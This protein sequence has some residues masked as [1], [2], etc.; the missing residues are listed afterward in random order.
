M[1]SN[2]VPLPDIVIPSGTAV[3]GMVSGV[4]QYEDSFGIMLYSPATLPESV[5]IECTPDIVATA[6]STWYPYETFDVSGNSINLF[7]P[8]AGKCQVYQEP[9]FAGSF[10]LHSTTNVAADRTFKITKNYTR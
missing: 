2:I 9:V 1:L 3:S 7:V 10:R 6:S 8:G 4:M 5:Y